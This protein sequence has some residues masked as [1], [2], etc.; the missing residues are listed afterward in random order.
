MNGHR[1][2]CGYKTKDLSTRSNLD[3]LAHGVRCRKNKLFDPKHPK[4]DL[5]SALKRHGLSEEVQARIARL[6]RSKSV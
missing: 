3:Y 5:T 1:C 2:R 4:Q 6:E